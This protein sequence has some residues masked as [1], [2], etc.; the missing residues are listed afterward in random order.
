MART[1]DG[2]SVWQNTAPRTSF[3][4]LEA[5]FATDV[6]VVGAGM[7]G[8]TTALLLRREGRAVAVLEAE[9]VG[10]GTSGVTSAHVTC[11][12]DLRLAKLQDRLGAPGACTYMKDARA[13]LALMQDLARDTAGPCDWATVPA[14]LLAE[15]PASQ[16]AL[17]REA[18]AAASLGLPA[19][20][21]DR[22]PLPFPV[23]GAVLYPNQARFHPMKYL[24]GLA[25]SVR[26]AG[27]PVFEHT[28][29]RAWKEDA[30]VV[31]LDTDRGAVAARCV[32]FA[33]HTPVGFNLVHTELAPYR[34]YVLALRL[35]EEVPDALFW[36]TAE[37]YHY[38]R[39]LERSGEDLLI[40]GGEDRKAGPEDDALDRHL[41]LEDYARARFTVD[42][43]THR[44]A[45]QY[46][47]PADGLPYVG[48]SPMAEEVFIATGYSGNGLV[49]GTLAARALVDR[50]QGRESA[51]GDLLAATRLAPL[52]A[53]TSV[54]ATNLRAA[55]R[56][57]GDRLGRWE[58]SLSGLG[59][60]EGR[61]VEVDGQKLAVYRDL[62][63]ALHSRS[64]VCTH[65]GC[66]VGWN[67]VERSWD[68]PCH[69]GRFS[70]LG[71]VIGG[72]PLEDLPARSLGD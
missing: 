49:Q 28:R 38:M 5:P 59:L 67:A 60:G 18:D 56:F 30:S 23:A 48:R 43:V 24:H 1:S 55:A 72:P 15:S 25:R 9:Q 13:A 32:V 50:L 69:G 19:V 20:L 58:K 16:T 37:P 63:G 21:T 3:P 14:Y 4:T 12:P 40:L 45:G 64:P 70:P 47:E 35:R 71:Q 33:T 17:R 62:K 22:T 11:I 7:T 41:A 39:R 51:V 53:A 2:S 54:A 52:A 36:D 42:C 46:Y 27:G 68:C 10:A 34:S 66:I 6:V 65:L 29:V 31:T 44:W 26:D 57:L 61:L 8:L